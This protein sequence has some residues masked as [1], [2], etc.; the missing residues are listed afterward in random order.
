M[1]QKLTPERAREN[2]VASGFIPLEPYVGLRQNWLCRRT[3]CGHE[4]FAKY[5]Y[6]Q[7]GT[8][9]CPFCSGQTVLIGFN[10]LA[11]KFPE[12]AA[13]A[14]GWDPRTVTVK[15]GK[16]VPWRCSLNHSWNARIASRTD[17]R[18]CPTC[19]GHK[20]QVGFNDLKTRFPEI[21]AQAEG[22]DPSTVNPGS[23]VK[24]PWVCALGH[25]WVAAIV[26][27][28]SS[29]RG[30]PYCSNNKVLKGFSDLE[31][32]FPEIA[33]QANGWDPSTV[34]SKSKQKRE[35]VCSKGHVWS[36]AVGSRTAGG[37]GCPV[38]RNLV[39]IT[40]VNDLKTQFPS[41]AAQADGWDPNV[42]NSGSSNRMS[43]KC[44]LGHRW[45][46]P[47]ASRTSRNSGCPI[48]SNLY[49][50]K[51]FND[52][53]TTHPEIAALAHGWDP[54]TVISGSHK[55]REWK[56]ELGHISKAK[57]QTR[58]RG[59]G[60]PICSNLYLLKGFNDLATTHPEIAALAHGWDPSTVIAGTHKKY[61]WKCEVGHEWI[62][63]PK[64]L[65]FSGRG[66]PSCTKYGYTPAADGWFYFLHHSDLNLYQIGISNTPKDRLRQH[67]LSGWE[68]LELRGPM[69]GG[70]TQKLERDALKAL[71][72][73]KAKFAN[74]AG[75]DKFDGYSE[76][77]T[78][79]SLNVTSIK[80]ILEWVYED[81]GV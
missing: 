54:S 63:D 73:R 34:S 77:W 16:K 14:D 20:V 58:A 42:V 61:L 19:S 36:A 38:C 60:C 17:G 2:A 5:E 1:P 21:A 53:A 32:K 10:D 39:T 15:S 27:R 31:T 62:T 78:K 68:T 24:K 4:F 71:K 13:Q 64:H 8:Q 45:A 22:W 57:I 47:V 28:T 33:A 3:Q 66:C 25:H 37:N 46:T 40:G 11:S 35:W 44:E 79:A 9:G 65:A 30:C 51:G 67:E 69:D 26:K 7:Q 56:C 49:L 72:K 23:D 52:L 12:V 55:I 74:K 70:Y 80:Q 6:I 41:I 75:L 43:W 29:G 59:V 81:E 18:G 76:A 50:L 48:C